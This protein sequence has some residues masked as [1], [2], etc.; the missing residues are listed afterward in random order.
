[1]DV[2]PR[3]GIW[4]LA[5]SA[6]DRTQGRYSMIEHSDEF[7]KARTADLVTERVGDELVVYDGR[8]SEAHCLSPLASAVFVAADGKTSTAD[9]AAI[10]SR[11][12]NEPVDVPT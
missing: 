9:L 2:A 7:P 8:S 12:I 6:S 1:M 10:A 5:E 4:G 11:Q 3:V